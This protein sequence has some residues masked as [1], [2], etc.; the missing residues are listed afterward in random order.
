[1]KL[2]N[3]I[4]IDTNTHIHF[5]CYVII[6]NSMSTDVQNHNYKFNENILDNKATFC[7]T[8]C[9]RNQP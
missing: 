8:L 6:Y 9:Y 3:Y 4:I 1:M 2:L 7:K 5:R